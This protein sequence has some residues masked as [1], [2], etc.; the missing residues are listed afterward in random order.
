VGLS[1]L[2]CTACQSTPQ[3]KPTISQKKQINPPKPDLIKQKNSSKQSSEIATSIATLI[4]KVKPKKAQ[5]YNSSGDK[6]GVTNSNGVFQT[7]VKFGIEETYFFKKSGY[8]KKSLKILANSEFLISYIHLEQLNPLLALAESGDSKAQLIIGDHYFEGSNGFESDLNTANY[9]Y[10][11]SANQGNLEAKS[12]LC[13]TLSEGSPT[14]PETNLNHCEEAAKL[15]NPTALYYLGIL[16][17]EDTLLEKDLKKAK[18]YLQKSFDLGLE[19]AKEE[20]DNLN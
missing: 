11:N 9:F 19:E 5:V 18:A 16:Y 13:A 10:L 15:N 17:T 7:Q 4:F 8:S 14:N 2:F 20:L 1:H 12:R 6:L 3:I